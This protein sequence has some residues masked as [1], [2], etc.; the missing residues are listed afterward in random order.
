MTTRHEAQ[1]F[2]FAKGTFGVFLAPKNK[3]N[4]GQL[5]HNIGWTNEEDY[6]TFIF[7]NGSVHTVKLKEVEKAEKNGIDYT[8]LGANWTNV[9]SLCQ[10]H[11]ILS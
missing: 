10:F 4:Y 2:M 5:L 11:L 1:T 3:W 9:G 6:G 7:D 8:N